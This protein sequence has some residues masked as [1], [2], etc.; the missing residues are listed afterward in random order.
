MLFNTPHTLD[1]IAGVPKHSARVSKAQKQ[2]WDSKCGFGAFVD[3]AFYVLNLCR[4][5]QRNP[6]ITVVAQ[7]VSN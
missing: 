4:N 7:A 2:D 1:L 3:K 6:L 5:C